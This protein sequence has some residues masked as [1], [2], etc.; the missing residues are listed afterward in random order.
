MLE[1][2]LTRSQ[3]PSRAVV[4]GASGFVGCAIADALENKGA[5]VTRIG[6]TEVDLLASDSATKLARLIEGAQS[7][8]LVSA[9]APVKNAEML[10]QNIQMI[11]V[12]AAAVRDAQPAHVLN[13]GSDAVFADCSA[14][15]NET[16]CRGAE[17]LHGIM[18]LT[19]EVMLQDAQAGRSFATLRPTLI[20]GANDPHNGYG[21][22]RFM[23][24]AAANQPITLFGEGEERRDH[25]WIGDVAELAARIVLYRS[26]G[27]L[28]AVTGQVTSFRDLAGI[29][30]TLYSGAQIIGSKRQGLMPHD[31]FR[32][33]D[34]SAISKAFP[35]HAMT[36]P[37]AGLRC[38]FEE[39]R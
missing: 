10:R 12:M 14:P 4:V 20:Y 11:D 2:G 38:V 19:R 28:N 31:G 13:I 18:H 9:I 26:T 39:L 27:S 7:V 34:A 6:R 33:F 25:V 17:S 37:Q 21:P 16:S 32:P 30:S 35:D 1:H 3:A 22:N 5:S 29:V 24:Q 36:L 15:L 23:R 8:V